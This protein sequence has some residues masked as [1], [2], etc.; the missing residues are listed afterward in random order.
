MSIKDTSRPSARVRALLLAGLAVG[1]VLAAALTSVLGWRAYSAAATDRATAAAMDAAKGR[2]A[3]LLTFSAPTLDAD[4]ARAKLQVTGEFVGRFDRLTSTLIA[5]STKQQGI[6]TK[7]VVARS[8]VI[9]AG[10][11][12]VVTLLLFINQT[13][14]TAAAPQPVQHMS[15]AK[16]TMSRVGDAWL[17]SDLIPI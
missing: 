2:A 14:S 8:A 17:I 15:Q 9:D 10:S 11:D 4:L 3:D 5:P 6:T 12:R 13:T 16:V 1:V 7:A